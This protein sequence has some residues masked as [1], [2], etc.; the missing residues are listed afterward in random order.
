VQGGKVVGVSAKLDGSNVAVTYIGGSDHASLEHL[1][2][3]V[4]DGPGVVVGTIYSTVDSSTSVLADAVKPDVGTKMVV[5]ISGKTG[6]FS[7]TVIGKFSD[8]TEV[9]LLDKTL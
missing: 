5:D 3:T 1:K 7:V 6:P 4:R 9:P 2:V 8:G